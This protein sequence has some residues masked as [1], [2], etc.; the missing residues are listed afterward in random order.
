[1]TTRGAPAE[2]PNQKSDPVRGSWLARIGQRSRPRAALSRRRHHVVGCQGRS[3]PNAD[4]FWPYGST[5]ACT[6]IRRGLPESG[7]ASRLV[8]YLGVLVLKLKPPY[9][10]R[11]GRVGLAD[12]P[13]A[14]NDFVIP[15]DGSGVQRQRVR[16]AEV[17]ASTTRHRTGRL[18]LPVPQKLP[19]FPSTPEA[20]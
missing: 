12:Y 7:T 10:P 20:W 14:A 15:G 6:R 5:T 18:T 9:L 4:S 2:F 8:Y 1:V 11:P 3:W 19:S 17:V 13:K 16:D